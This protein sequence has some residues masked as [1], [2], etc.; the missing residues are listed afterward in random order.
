EGPA[1]SGERQA[2]LQPRREVPEQ[3][4]A[5]DVHRE[6][7]PRPLTGCV[8]ERLRESRTRERANR[9]AGEDRRELARVE[10][11]HARRLPFD[12]SPTACKDAAPRTYGRLESA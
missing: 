3:Q 5:R 12:T 1:V 8:R 4:R 10:G 11:R 2:L 6:R 7:R 9:P